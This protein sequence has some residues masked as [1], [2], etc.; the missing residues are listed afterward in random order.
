VLGAVLLLLAVRH[1]TSPSGAGLSLAPH[2]GE[3]SVV[4]RRRTTASGEVD[5]SR[6][7]EAQAEVAVAVD[8]TNADVLLA[9]SNSFAPAT[10]VY[11]SVDG[12]ATW[13]SDQ[14]EVPEPS[15][16][17]FGDPAVAIGDDGRQYLA[18]LTGP[19]LQVGSL[20]ISLGLATRANA[21]EPWSTH[22]LGVPG[23]STFSDKDSLAIDTSAA[24][25]HHGRLYVAWSRFTRRRSAFEL[26][27][28]HSDDAGATWS[29][30]ARVNASR[31]AGETYSSIAT[32]ADGSV[33]VA[34]M[35]SDKRIF[36][37]RSTDGG[38]HFA[39]PLAAGTAV[40]AGLGP[41]N[42]GG[43]RLLAQPH[44]CVAP[45]PLVT[46]DRPR[47][48][49]FV[50]F[51]AAGA[52]GR[53]QNVYVT[54]YEAGTL[55][56]LLVRHRINPPDGRRASDQFLPV[57]AVD[58]STGRLWACWYDTTGDRARKRVRFTCSASDDGAVTW[59]VPAPVA[60]VF[61]NETVKAATSFEYGDYAG[62]AVASGVA[63]PMWTD[64]RDLVELQEEIYTTRLMIAP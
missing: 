60:S 13:T 45:A 6:A 40:S 8:P 47:A 23:E 25:P 18:F 33:F 31:T 38:D 59:T 46:V 10:Q 11:G 5:V 39:S 61:S 22:V 14:V 62:L 42:F 41:C 2:A 3:V 54:A 16:C 30:A 24:S 9:A 64:S 20:H 12:G 55:A 28:S 56:P 7:T 19:C 50:T 43:T 34:W 51:G 27:L 1:A 58:E 57:S 26:V 48:R 4:A 36:L 52:S 29:P 17:A 49:V 37:A 21:S 63:H 35:T 32:S 53:E 44:R 15:L